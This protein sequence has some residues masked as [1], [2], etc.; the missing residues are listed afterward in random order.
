MIGQRGLYLETRWAERP[1]VVIT[2]MAEAWHLE[3]ASTDA[4]ATEWAAPIGACI[5][6]MWTEL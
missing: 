2:I 4:M 1:D 6:K 5:C 3:A